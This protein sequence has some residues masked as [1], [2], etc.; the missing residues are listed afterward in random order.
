M[1]FLSL[2]PYSFFALLSIS[3]VSIQ[4]AEKQPNIVFF[5]TDDQTTDSIGCY[6]NPIM[7]TPQID[8][9]AAS[10]VRFDR[11]YVSQPI[12]WVSRTTILTGLTGRSSGI[13]ET[14]DRPR[15]ETVET[16][17]SDILR[18]AG[19]RTG[20]F[21][22]WHAMMP[23]GYK[24]AD[25]FDDFE[26]IFRDPFF[27]KLPDGSL[28]HET[29]LIVDRGIEFIKNQPADKPFALNMWFN[30]GHGEDRDRRPGRHFAWPPSANHL[31]QDIELPNRPLRDP[32]I[33]ASQPD[34]LQTT[35]ARNRYFWRWNTEEKYD[36][37]MR[38]YMRMISGIDHAI[39]RFREALE[40]AGLAENTI[41]VYSADN[42]FHLA[43]RGLSGK[44]SHYE[45]SIRVPLIIYDP[46]LPEGKRGRV[47][48][49][50]ALN[51]DFP[52]TF[53]D[54]A[55]VDIPS[56]YQGRSLAPVIA[57]KTPADWPTQT[58]HEH[59]AVRHR[60]PAWE[61]I[62]NEHYKYAR[63]FDHGNFEFLHDLK[64][65][66]LERVNLAKDSK[67]AEVLE[68]MRAELDRSVAQHGG[69]ILPSKQP[70]ETSTQPHP[71]SAAA[72]AL[73]GGPDADG[74][75][76]LFTGNRK[77]DWDGD[78]A[79]WSAK[80][81]TIVI[82]GDGDPDQQRYLGWMGSTIHNFD[83][84]MKLQ[85]SENAQSGIQYRGKWIPEIGLDAFHGYEYQLNANAPNTVGTLDD[86][87]GR[88]PLGDTKKADTKSTL[89]P[90]Q[91]HEVRILAEGNRLRHWID[92][93][94]VADVTDNDKR[95]R[96]GGVLGLRIPTD[97]KAKVQFKDIRIRHLPD[98]LENDKE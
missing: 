12:C 86:V 84:R 73:Y 85:L 70:F 46:R 87:G 26:H 40:K 44:W 55:G 5:F 14:P 39:G 52:A 21:G 8:Q 28:R 20:Y 19:Y 13:P 2:I 75:F 37:N 83:L 50:A 15:P 82:T 16:L 57:D 63:Y 94:L 51:V 42:G 7:Q 61:G 90:N 81:D 69:P 32:K 45:E 88:G 78:K 24:P 59:F 23:K 68:K 3:P 54:W 31:Y 91:W 56:H 1:R 36:T 29:D 43:N 35:V 77:R 27:K 66:P 30:A 92:D 49:A 25:H 67:H 10:G 80:N 71:S 76:H 17:Y 62:R 47:T 60:I 65:D 72:G 89:K 22:K 93:Q 79:Y 41:I 4:A 96:S 53:L 95:A 33:F 11:A 98:Q 74:W 97:P 34:F 18:A 38:A 58:F 9:L 64:N 6:G 48:Q